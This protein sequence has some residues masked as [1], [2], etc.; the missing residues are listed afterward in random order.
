MVVLFSLQTFTDTGWHHS[1]FFYAQR[2][3]A[4]HRP[5]IHHLPAPLETVSGLKESPT[6]DQLISL[7][8][9]RGWLISHQANVCW[10]Y[11]E[12]YLPVKNPEESPRINRFISSNDTGELLISTRGRDP[13]PIEHLF[14]GFKIPNCLLYIP[15]SRASKN[16]PKNP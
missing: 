11:F 5:P 1:S 4:G 12:F 6:M 7:N 10:L 8:H 2:P 3:S 15:R 14:N 13:I 9:T 16:R